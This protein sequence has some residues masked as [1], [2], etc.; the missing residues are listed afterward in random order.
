MALG[1][2]RQQRYT[3]WQSR[4]ATVGDRFVYGACGEHVEHPSKA[5][6]RQHAKTHVRRVQSG[7]IDCDRC[8]M[9]MVVQAWRC[10]LGIKRHWHFGHSWGYW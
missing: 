7:E 4:P 5:V 9:G 6:A 2:R 8:R 1:E 3:R 10:P